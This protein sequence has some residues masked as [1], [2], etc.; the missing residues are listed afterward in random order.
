MLAGIGY[1]AYLLDVPQTWI[2][3]GGLIIVGAATMSS[4]S[5]IKRHF[6]P[7]EAPEG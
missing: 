5:H 3:V 2:I 7:D 6:Y 4:G 1:G